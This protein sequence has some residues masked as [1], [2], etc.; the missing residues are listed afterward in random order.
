MKR[1]FRLLAA[2]LATALVGSLAAL[3]STSAPASA[4]GTVT[5]SGDHTIGVLYGQTWGIRGVTHDS[6]TGKAV[7]T[8]TI[9]LYGRRSAASAWQPLAQDKTPG[10]YSFAFRPAISFQV[11]IRYTGV[12]GGYAANNTYPINVIVGRDHKGPF[13][14][15]RRGTTLTGRVLPHYGHRKVFIFKRKCGGGCKFFRYAK[16][17][18]N[19]RGWWRVQIPV[20]RMRYIAVVPRTAG[21]VASHSREIAVTVHHYYSRSSAPRLLPSPLTGSAGMKGV[22]T[23]KTASFSS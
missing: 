1:S 3:V 11:M 2:T 10:S 14:K 23:G 9:T 4:A 16:V 15:G 6:A 20:R 7:T 18:T 19:R 12:S 8:G 17:R 13:L 21:Y 22:A 5:L